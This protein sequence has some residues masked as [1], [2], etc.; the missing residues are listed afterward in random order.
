MEKNEYK[1]KGIVLQGLNSVRKMLKK[2][3]KTVTYYLKKEPKDI[4]KMIKNSK[5][6]HK[7]ELESIRKRK[8]FK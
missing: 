2:Q 8:N 4:K 6:Q 1:E 3:I 5:E 7:P